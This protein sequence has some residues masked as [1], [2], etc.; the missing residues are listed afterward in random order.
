[1]ISARALAPLAE[2][3]D[4]AWPLMGRNV[5]AAF[6]KGADF[7]KG[8]AEA[9]QS[10]AFDLIEHPSRVGEGAILEIANLRRKPRQA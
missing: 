9:S 2:L 5:P 6:H 3:L 7:R 10:F 8:V 4:L 1:M